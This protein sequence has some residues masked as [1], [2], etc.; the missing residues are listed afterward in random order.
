MH[1][2][3][4]TNKNSKISSEEFGVT[5]FHKTKKKQIFKRYT[6][7]CLYNEVS[8]MKDINNDKIHMKMS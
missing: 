5:Y 3:V 4:L 1:T 7:H 6:F 8:L 2:E